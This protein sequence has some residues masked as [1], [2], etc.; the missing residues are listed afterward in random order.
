M[1]SGGGGSERLQ[2]ENSGAC[3]RAE[4]PLGRRPRPR[5]RPVPGAG[6]VRQPRRRLRH[7]PRG[8]GPARQGLRPAGP[9]RRRLPHRDEVGLPGQGHRQADLPGRQRRRG[10]ARHL[11]GHG[12]AR[13][14][15]ARPGRGPDRVR[16]R[17]RLQPGVHLPARRMRLRRPAP[18]RGDQRGLRP[19]PARPRRQGLRVRP[20]RGPA[21]RRWGLHLRRGDGPAVLAG[22]TARTA[23]AAPALPGRRGPVPGPDHRQQ[24]RDDRHRALDRPQGRRL[25]PVHGQRQVARARSCSASPA[26]CGGRATTS[27]RWV[28]PRAS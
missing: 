26:T 23:Q 3:A 1:E 28:H 11:Q 27:T 12:A 20:G 21:P 15:P 14:R 19:R 8:P 4:Q 6:R 13:T 9:G 25:V 5:D 22:G 7:R 24:R 16:L 10:R 2:D 18:G 17:D